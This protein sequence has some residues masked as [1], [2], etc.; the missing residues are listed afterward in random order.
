LIG[1][2][3]PG[4]KLVIPTGIPDRQQLMVLE[5][6]ADGKL[7]TREVLPVRFSELED[8]EGAAGAA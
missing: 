5:K 1:Q 7:G 6:S 8:G 2:L 4:G 3:K